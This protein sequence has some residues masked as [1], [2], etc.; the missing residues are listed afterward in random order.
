MLNGGLHR[1]PCRTRVRLCTRDQPPGKKMAV[2][3]TTDAVSGM[4]MTASRPTSRRIV[5]YRFESA[6]TP[7][8]PC[9]SRH[10]GAG[11]YSQRLLAWLPAMENPNRVASVTNQRRTCEG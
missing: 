9:Y 1:V 2:W 7:V 3:G 6:G 10:A 4:V 11:R 5:C 8:P